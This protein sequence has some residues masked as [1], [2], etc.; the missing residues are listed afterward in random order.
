MRIVLAL[1]A[2][3]AVLLVLCGWQFAEYRDFSHKSDA[4]GVD[5]FFDGVYVEGVDVS[6][7]TLDEA[8]AHWENEIEPAY[9]ARTVTLS[10]GTQIVSSHVGYDSNYRQVLQTAFDALPQRRPAASSSRR[11]AAWARA[12]IMPF[13]ARIARARRWRALRWAS[14]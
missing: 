14:R 11:S 3:I 1:A 10:D 12:W 7:M 13:R 9:A 5:T 4:V 2:L 6:G 8:L